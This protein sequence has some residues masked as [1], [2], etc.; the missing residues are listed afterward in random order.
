MCKDQICARMQKKKMLMLA[1][2]FT[3][4]DHFRL[5]LVTL[6][7]SIVVVIK[8]QT[9]HLVYNKQSI[10][11]VTYHAQKQT[12]K[13]TTVRFTNKQWLVTSNWTC[14]INSGCTQTGQEKTCVFIINRESHN[15]YDTSNCKHV[16]FTYFSVV[17]HDQPIIEIYSS[18]KKLKACN[19]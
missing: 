14:K 4:I 15:R 9:H 10:N 3:Y 19:N 6:I 11:I 13:Q 2:S 17:L 12:K 7:I 1:C 18:T 16:S 8:K 5:Y